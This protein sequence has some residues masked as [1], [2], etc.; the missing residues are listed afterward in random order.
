[1]VAFDDCSD[2]HVLK[3]IRFIRQ[4]MTKSLEE[5]DVSPFRADQGKS[6][7]YRVARL[8]GKTQITAFRRIGAVDRPWNAPFYNF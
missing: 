2:D 3:V 4:N 8:M 5:V 6:V 1:V 7:K